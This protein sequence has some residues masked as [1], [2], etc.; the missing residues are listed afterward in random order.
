LAHALAFAAVL[1]QLRRERPL[2]E[3]YADE[4]IALS[5]EHGL[6]VYQAMARIVRGWALI[7]RGDDEQAAREMRQG[8]SAWQSTGA[9]LMRP[10]YLALL[11]EASAPTAT[12]DP[13]LD[14]LDEA[15]ALADSTGERCYQAELYRLKGERLLASARERGSVEAAATCL[16]Q[17][18]ATARRQGALSLELRAAMSLT[19]LPRGR[20]G[21]LHARRLLLSVY[22]RFEEGFDTPDLRD[23]RGLLDLHVD[24]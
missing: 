13:G 9:Q 7:G 23:A 4:A 11:A 6:V 21:S 15:L 24:R 10:H 5:G 17:S 12:N 1:H 16:E 3:R 14:L 18:L 2:A 19:R 22:E 20:T 8:K